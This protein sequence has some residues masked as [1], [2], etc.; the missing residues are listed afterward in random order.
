MARASRALG[1]SP[2]A[3]TGDEL[4]GWVSAQDWA[5][6]TRRS[7]YG[8][9][10]GFWD[11]GVGSGRCEV[12]PAAVLPAV[13]AGPARPRPTPERSYRAALAAADARER[14]IL[15]LAAECGL[16]RAE[17]AQIHARDLLEDLGGWSLVVHGK[18]GRDREVPMAEGL[19]TIVRAQLM[20]TGGWLLPG[21]D[22][23]HL[24]P[25]Y[26]GILASRLLP[27]GW[28]LHTLRHRCASVAY[29][30][31]RDLLGVQALLGH[32][33]VATTQRYVKVPDDAVRRA[34]RRAAAA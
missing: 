29:A 19:A 3:V 33:S 26:V 15:R 14:L 27:D 7:V 32:A 8:S 18:G 30:V 24:S 28:T 23:G 10:R 21:G 2:W 31:D 12:S 13:A 16:R 22:H 9:L 20:A 17:I 11:W 5:R 34:V 25:R 4:T 6:E 1:G